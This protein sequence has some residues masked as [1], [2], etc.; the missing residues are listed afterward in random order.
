LFVDLM[1]EVI[2]SDVRMPDERRRGRRDKGLGRWR[3]K[4]LR[5]WRGNERRW[6]GRGKGGIGFGRRGRRTFDGIRRGDECWGND[7]GRRGLK[8][9][10][11]RGRDVRL[12]NQSRENRPRISRHIEGKL[13]S[14]WGTGRW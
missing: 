6:R 9:R 12:D 5:R 7:V 1:S 3:D 11:R 4:G 2:L 8:I 10:G 14:R 13:Q